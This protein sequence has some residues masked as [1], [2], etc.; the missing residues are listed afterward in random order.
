M[1]FGDGCIPGHEIGRA[2]E[3][4]LV[5]FHQM[6]EGFPVAVLAALDGF[7]IVHGARPITF[8]LETGSPDNMQTAAKTFPA[9]PSNPG[10]ADD[11]TERGRWTTGNQSVI[12]RTAD[13]EGR[14][15]APMDARQAETVPGVLGLPS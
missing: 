14:W 11:S 6:A 9:G 15:R 12:R 3:N 4:V 7:F 1:L 13:L 2:V 5:S 10:L 8:P